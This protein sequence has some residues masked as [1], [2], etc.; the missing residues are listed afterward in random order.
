[1]AKRKIKVLIVD[2]QVLVLDI[3]AKGLSR[4]PGIEVVGTATDGQLALNQIPR[5]QPDVIVLDME[6][7]RMN[8]IQFL[9]KLM[10]INPI[11]TI[12][13]SALTQKDSRITKE[14]FE[15]GAVDFLPKPSGGAK[16]LPTL[17]V[18][19]WTKIRIAA[20]QDLSHLKKTSLPRT[21]PSNELDRQA[22]TNQSILGMGA[23]DVTNERD[24]ILKI[25]AL[26]SCIGLALYCPSKQVIGMSH[27]VLPSSSTDAAKAN[28]M[29]GYFADTAVNIMLEKMHEQGC[30]NASI[31][32]KLA[33]GAKTNVDLGDYFGIGQR[34]AVAV[35]ATLLKKGVKILA[36]DL[37]GTISRT[38]FSRV[39][40]AKLYLSHPD[41]GNWEL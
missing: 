16:A 1:M 13:L 14:A 30:T 10:P 34:N 35:K 6:M 20:T 40:D 17:F 29:P 21:L 24:R 25:F 8:G 12:V 4:D 36:E 28:S 41:K 5:I 23:F 19:L 3:L 33:G 39:G 22:R 31:V 9:H 18:Q 11:P 26:G 27:V 15:L 7:P 2:D 37:G 32:A 38:I